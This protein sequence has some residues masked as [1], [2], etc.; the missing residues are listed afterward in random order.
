MTKNIIALIVSGAWIS[1]SE[2]A[3]AVFLIKKILVKKNAPA[4]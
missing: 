1:L 3:I 4:A 2:V